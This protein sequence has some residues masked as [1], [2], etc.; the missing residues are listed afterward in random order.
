MI[1]RES[2]SIN[3]PN[4]L[5]VNKFKVLK[6]IGCE[7]VPQNDLTFD[8]EGGACNSFI[9]PEHMVLLCFDFAHAAECHA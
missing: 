4:D 3:L 1:Q 7:L 8:F 6:I 9:R 5:Y 2:T